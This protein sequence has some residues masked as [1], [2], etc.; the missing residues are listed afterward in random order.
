[1]FNSRPTLLLIVIIVAQN[2]HFPQAGRIP[3]TTTH[4][5]PC[6][7]VMVS[8]G[9]GFLSDEAHY[10]VPVLHCVIRV[11]GTFLV[12]KYFKAAHLVSPPPL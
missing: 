10:S 2:C 3:F 1:M 11:T 7:S 8:Y 4:V 12:E 6:C 5:L 9:D